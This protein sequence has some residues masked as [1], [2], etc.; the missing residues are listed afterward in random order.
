[1]LLAAFCPACGRKAGY[2]QINKI[3]FV[4]VM[5]HGSQVSYIVLRCPTFCPLWLLRWSPCVDPGPFSILGNP[6]LQWSKSRHFICCCG[7]TCSVWGGKEGEEGGRKRCFCLPPEYV[8]LASPAD[9]V[10]GGRRASVQ[11]LQGWVATAAVSCTNLLLLLL[12]GL[13]GCSLSPESHAAQPEE[14][15]LQAEPPPSPHGGQQQES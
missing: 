11:A 4:F 5:L 12:L 3:A 2:K 14:V 9:P 6:H 7:P 15:G 1:M 8:L 13:A 10:S